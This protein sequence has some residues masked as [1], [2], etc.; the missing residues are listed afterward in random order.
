MHHVISN[1][2]FYNRLFPPILIFVFVVLFSY[3]SVNAKEVIWAQAAGGEG[4]QWGERTTIGP[5]N[6]IIV[7]GR[8]NGTIRFGEGQENET[9]LTADDGYYC[10]FIAKYDS[11]GFF[12]WARQ[13]N[14]FMKKG[15]PWNAGV[16]ETAIDNRC[17]INMAGF[18]SNLGSNQQRAAGCDH[19]VRSKWFLGYFF[20]SVFPGR[21]IEMGD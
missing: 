3:S 15:Y 1:Q 2:T 12:Q 6:E 20:S 11:S 4:D 9:T 14:V 7:T 13:I 18:F 21:K 17:N 8:F 10:F 19:A 5:E 16:P